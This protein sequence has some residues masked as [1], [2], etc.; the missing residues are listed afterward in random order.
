MKHGKERDFVKN[1]IILVIKLVGK[2]DNTIFLWD[3]TKG[4]ENIV[5]HKNN[6][7]TPKQNTLQCSATQIHFTKIVLQ[8]EF[9]HYK[10]AFR[11]I[12]KSIFLIMCIVQCNLEFNKTQ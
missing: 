8:D 10:F 4:D 12:S 3:S 1:I 7:A 11:T 5:R 2:K 9:I 6:R